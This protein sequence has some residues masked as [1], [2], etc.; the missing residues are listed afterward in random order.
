MDQ[1]L[2]CPY[3][4]QTVAVSSDLAGQTAQCPYCSGEFVV[5]GMAVPQAPRG[6]APVV[7][8]RSLRSGGT[9]GVRSN[10]PAQ[11]RAASNDNSRRFLIGAAA[12]LA[13][14]LLPLGA[15]AVYLLTRPAAPVAQA[16]EPAVANPAETSAAPT[17]EA[18]PS[19]TV[20][21]GGIVA[22][23]PA[24]P[25]A[26][27]PAS[28]PAQN[29]ALPQTTIA[30]PTGL[31]S[32]TN[33]PTTILPPA[34]VPAAASIPTTPATP[35]ALEPATPAAT[36]GSTREVV[37]AI[38]PSVVVIEVPGVGLGSGFVVDD[39]GTIA[40]NYHVI[41]GAKTAKATFLIDKTS[42]DIQGFLVVAPGKDLAILKINPGNYRL[43]PLP[44]SAS[45]P[46]KGESVLAFGAPKGFG[47]SVSDGII[48][49]VRTGNDI[50]ELLMAG[51]KRDIYTEVLGYDRD[52]VWLQTTAPISGGNSGGPLV[53]L[54][55]EVV[56]LNT[57]NRTDGQ[58]LNF[59]ISAEHIRQVMQSAQSGLRPLAQLPPP[60]KDSGSLAMGDGKRTLEY[61][62]QIGEVN[63]TMYD[64]LKKVPRPALPTSFK[65]S[66]N[67]GQKVMNFYRKW[68][69]ILPE[70]ASQLKD[71]DVKDVDPEL[72]LL[73]TAD[74]MMMESIAEDLRA[75]ALSAEAGRAKI[76]DTDMIM[77]KSYGGKT[78][79]GQTYDI[80][81]LKYNVQYGVTFPNIAGDAP[82]S[83]VTAKTP[84]STTPSASDDDDDAGAAAPATPED[85][86]KAAARGLALAKQM[87]KN[88]ITRDA[89]RERLE[90]IIA[91][92]P[93]TKAAAEAK[94]LLAG[95]GA[96]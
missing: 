58:N 23:A 29:A 28:L 16:N 45:R 56:G 50:R 69:E 53:N 55:S 92:F 26:V 59:A 81:R 21:S 27:N 42:F 61:W 18:A 57:W 46:E 93:G 87:L 20:L 51:S 44:L 32:A 78:T 71:L 64:K 39:Q 11:K 82:R 54:R 60:R 3:C 24:S 40:T 89:G 88:P 94:E 33:P 85:R 86:E 14:L 96:K 12:G 52:A 67:F 65:K 34:S 90:K 31:N 95:M 15:F 13:A 19:A 2:A 76:F 41:E 72:V 75:L 5:P 47:G 10:R 7:P 68:A 80:L 22:P 66:R 91:D 35:P 70:S 49:A 25:P 8:N 79:I 74:A 37:Q 73:V 38:E 36:S 9:A 1:H 84:T 6:A 4:Q 63:R 48:S 30:Q 77:R 83:K 62:K 17:V 43:R